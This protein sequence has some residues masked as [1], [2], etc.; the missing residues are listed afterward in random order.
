MPALGES[1]RELSRSAGAVR[2]LL[3]VSHELVGEKGQAVTDGLSAD[4]AHRFLVAG[5]AEQA[6]AGPDHERVDEQP[7]LV[8]EVVLDQRAPELIAGVDDDIPV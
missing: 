4:E 3:G 8:D 6:L 7:K 5:L 1:A 2:R